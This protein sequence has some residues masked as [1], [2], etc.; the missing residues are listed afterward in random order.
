MITIITIGKK[1]EPW[2]ESG[3]ER[4]EKR[5]KQPWNITWVLLPHSSLE[6]T[7]ARSE[8]SQR[9]A[10]RISPTDYVILLDETG[11]S[12]SSPTLSGL[13]ERSFGE[14]KAITMIIGGAYGVTNELKQ[15][16]DTVWSLSQLVFPHQL[17]RLV[18]TEQLY[19][20]QSIANGSQYHHS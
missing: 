13:L 7:Q 11:K 4:Y 14:G 10:R 5:L 8:E 18:L 12:F 6:G 1:H 16:A 15:R 3:I 17:V 9:I 20:A 2:V 19:R